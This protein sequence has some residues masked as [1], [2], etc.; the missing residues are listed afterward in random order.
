MDAL[1]L[2]AFFRVST[3]LLLQSSAA[4]LHFAAPQTNAARVGDDA[5]VRL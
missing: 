2:G 1:H 5:A 3:L 4:A